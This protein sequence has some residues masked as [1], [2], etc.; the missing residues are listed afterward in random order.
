MDVNASLNDHHAEARPRNFAYISASMKGLKQ[1]F[2]V[3]QGNPNPNIAHFEYSIGFFFCDG[4]VN[5]G[6]GRRI[7]HGIGKEIAENMPHYWLIGLS[8]GG[9]GLEFEHNTA[10][11]GGCGKLFVHQALTKFPQVD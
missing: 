7:L 8:L 6:P 2:L 9:D 3:L 10:F 1:V 11:V 5:G 4:E